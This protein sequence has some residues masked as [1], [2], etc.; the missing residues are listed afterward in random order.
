MAKRSRNR[1]LRMIFLVTLA[2]TVLIA[3]DVFL[4]AV[5]KVH[6]RSG[7]DL[8]VYADS[9][10][11]ITE[12][13]HALR[14][15]I[16]DRSGNVIA[17]DRK[18]YNIV[19]IL[20]ENRPAVGD[21]IAYVKDKEGTAEIL[22]DVLNMDYETVLEYL[23]QD[24]YQ[25]ELGEKG[26]NLPKGK[27][28]EIDSYDLPGIEFTDSIQRIYPYGT[29]ASNLIGYAQADENGMISGKMGLELYLNSYLT[30][31]DGSRSYQVDKQGYV[32]PGMKE[33][34]VS[35]SNGYNVYLTL[36]E[37]I[38]SSLEESMKMTSN[39]FNTYSVWGAAMEVK[40]GKII[41]W[42]QYPSFDANVRDITEYN[43]IGTQ[44]PYEPGSTLKTFTWAAAINE[45][46]Y[47]GDDTTNGNEFCYYWDEDDNPVRANTDRCIYNARMINYGDIDYDHGLIYSLNTVAAAIQTEN[48]TPQIHLDYL[49]KF[50]FFQKVD[51]DGIP[52]ING[53]LNFTW[54]GDRLSLCYGQGSTV[55]ML[56]L[57][58][59]YSAVFSDGTMVKP[60]FVESVRDS[61]DNSKVIY[62]AETKVV[63]N[64][65]KEET[66]KQL[67]EILTRT[68][69]D[70]DGSARNYKIPECLIMGKTGTTEWAAEGKYESGQTITSLM[71]AMPAED[72]QVMVYYAF[73][74]DYDPMAHAK[75]EPQI[76]F[77][78]KVAMTYG[79]SSDRQEEEG[80]TEEGTEQQAV[81]QIK[82][83]TMPNLL[84]HSIDYANDKLDD[85]DSDVLI[86]GDG[87]TVIDQFPRSGDFLVTGQRVF[88][89]TDT[90]S[91]VMPDLYGWTR[92]DVAALWA[93]TGF[94]FQ[95]AGEGKVISQNIPPG[96]VVT[97][98]TS[99]KVN[100]GLKQQAE[101]SED[102]E[103]E[104]QQEDENTE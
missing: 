24:V 101:V 40:T 7:T 44:L 38:Q 100:F 83:Y 41:A 51:T 62:Q 17:Q 58:Q 66:A 53:T 67:Q 20:D 34:T 61:Y 36:D 98:G 56:Q 48:I 27:K 13:I 18:T 2:A 82:K 25:T 76:N 6:L 72:P 22:S 11:T 74:A 45:G 59:A 89:L 63:G 10:N 99:I 1:E 50:G 93:V 68:A 71:A 73:R 46:K 9:A 42:G 4:V 39:M 80:E 91:F 97:R 87:D 19:C 23:S 88:L 79:F 78:R 84:N 85:L 104:E 102:T 31:T 3:S 65:I 57:L 81:T 43:D 103:A 95:L 60:Y 77:F 92:K 54:P 86:L 47:K 15:N 35:A 12:T 14:G 28:D 16:L 26:R 30:G 70:E 94:G 8:S 75:T 96:T 5:G 90:G 21:E 49:K 55:T 32:L 64:P 37:G 52:E 33:N 69:N 29:F